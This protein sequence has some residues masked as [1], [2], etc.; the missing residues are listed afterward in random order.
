MSVQI[1]DTLGQPLDETVLKFIK[2][3]PISGSSIVRVKAIDGLQHVVEGISLGE[4]T[5]AFSTPAVRSSIVNVQVFA[6]LRI[7]PRNVTLVLGA[8]LQVV[9][10]DENAS[11]LEEPMFP[12]FLLCLD[13]HR[14]TST[15]CCD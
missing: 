14:W 4:T 12:L 1:Y 9:T 7:N 3:K 11:L 8:T 13:K 2:L 10:T 6:P 15:R 5:I